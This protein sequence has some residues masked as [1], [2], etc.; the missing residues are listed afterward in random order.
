MGADVNDTNVI[1]R[2]FQLAPE[3]TT[4]DELKK[5]LVR[6]GY[7]QVSAHLS[8]RQIRTQ[9]SSLLNRGPDAACS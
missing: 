6:E 3:C 9:I 5:K 1:E 8:G 2:A 7:F 4:L